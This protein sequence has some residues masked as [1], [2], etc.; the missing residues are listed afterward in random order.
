MKHTVEVK[1][2]PAGETTEWGAFYAEVD[3]RAV[4]DPGQPFWRTR[5]QAQACGE[6]FVAIVYGEDT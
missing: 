3:G 6:R 1:R 4:G 2:L 5:K